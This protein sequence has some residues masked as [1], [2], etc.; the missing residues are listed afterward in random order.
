MKNYFKYLIGTLCISLLA[1]FRDGMKAHATICLG[2]VC[3]SID[4]QDEVCDD[5]LKLEKELF[6]KRVEAITASYNTNCGRHLE[7]HSAGREKLNA[8]KE[9]LGK[10]LEG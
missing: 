10:L 8:E 4:Q 9:R 1:S 5:L 2:K 7:A 6:I 3:E